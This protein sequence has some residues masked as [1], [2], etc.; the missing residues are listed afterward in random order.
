[1]NTKRAAIYARVSTAEQVD[2]T[3]LGTQVDTCRAY[4]DGQGW[5][6]HDSYIDE[7]VSGSKATRPALDRLLAAARVGT[8]QV[9]IVSKLDRIGRS[10]R[11]LAALLGELDDRNIVLVSVSEAFDSSTPSGRLHRNMLGSFAEFER[12]Q[13]RERMSS[14][15]DAAIRAGIFVSH[16]PY[17]YQSV[18]TGPDRRLALDPDEAPAVALAVDL[19]VNQR[20][21][22]TEVAAELNARA[23]RPRKSARWNGHALR[24][25]LINA[26]CISGTWTWRHP[27]HRNSGTQITM[28]VPAVIDAATHDRLRARLA[29]SSRPQN[30]HPDRYLLAGRIRSPHGTAMFGLT[31]NTRVYRCA[32]VFANNAP[33]GGRTCDCKTVRADPVEAIVWGE[34]CALLADPGRLLAMS[35]LQIATETS[36]IAAGA[37]DLTAIDRRIGRLEKAAGEQLARLL[38]DGLDPAVAAHAAR[39]LTDEIAAARRHRH[40][41]AAWQA[42]NAD[43]HHRAERL[44]DLARRARDILPDCDTLTKRRVLA[45]LEVQ[46]TVGGWDLCPTCQGSGYLPV[47]RPGQPSHWPHRQHRLGQQVICPDCH[48]H[49]HLPRLVIEGIVPETDLQTTLPT[50]NPERLPFRLV[51]TAI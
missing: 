22:L 32:D 1:V 10:M 41:V 11:H 28:A 4:A 33:P 15:R 51:G 24:V 3:S 20:Y 37:D 34:V 39:G 8:V 27:K 14:G 5:T 12:E 17:G 46:V 7:G 31:N 2:G 25:L 40:Q 16:A 29:E 9:V 43:R 44:H 30:R 26:D 45:L 13:I 35:G 18:G 50:D 48:R 47:Y 23:M 36:G 6:V 38:A 42:A 49:R 21:R 19:Y